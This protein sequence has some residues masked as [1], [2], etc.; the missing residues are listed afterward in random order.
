EVTIMAVDGEATV[1]VNGN[2]AGQAFEWSPLVLS[3]TRTNRILTDRRVQVFE[4]TVNVGY[5]TGLDMMADVANT[6][7]PAANQGSS[8]YLL[9]PLG[10]EHTTTL[11]TV[12]ISDAALASLRLNGV[13]IDSGLFAQIPDTDLHVAQIPLAPGSSMLTANQPFRALLSGYAPVTR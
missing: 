3:L 6:A 4:S 10:D 7:V 2:N 12:T 11:A 1:F 13:T 9:S 5:L 8:S